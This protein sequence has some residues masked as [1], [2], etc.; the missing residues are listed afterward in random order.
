MRRNICDLTRSFYTE[1]TTIIDHPI[2]H[3]KCIKD[4]VVSSKK[5]KLSMNRNALI[6][7]DL[8]SKCEGEG[9]EVPGVLPHVFFWHHSGSESAATVGLSKVNI[10]EA[11]MVC[12]LTAYLVKCGVPRSSIAVLT[13]YKGQMM[14][15]RSK[16][17][18]L[19]IYVWDAADTCRLSTVD[20]FQ[21]D[22][23]DVVVIS[24]VIGSKSTTPFV[25]LVNRMIV[26]LSRARIGLYIVANL[27]YFENNKVDHWEATLNLLSNPATNDTMT[28]LKSKS[29]A[30]CFAYSGKTMA[31]SGKPTQA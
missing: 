22:E 3:T 15:L 23:A 2:C 30:E 5:A 1:V 17:K 21:G 25:K 7:N 27:A 13:P 14:L 29:D 18:D 4:S 10:H 6:S 16:L 24:M 26:A 31:Y 28:S 9:R 11:D 12:A 20:R 8:I 19:N